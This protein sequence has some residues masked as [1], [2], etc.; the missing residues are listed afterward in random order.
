VRAADFA[1]DD[2]I[3]GGEDRGDCTV[4]NVFTEVVDYTRDFTDLDR[5]SIRLSS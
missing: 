3:L 5:L 1:V 4:H 2:V